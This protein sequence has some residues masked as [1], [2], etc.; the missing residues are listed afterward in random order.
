[1]GDNNL[2]TVGGE[3][4]STKIILKNL[5]NHFEFHVIQPGDTIKPISGINYKY[6]SEQDR[7]KK[8][9]KNPFLFIKYILDT[10]KI[11]NEINPN[12]IHTQ[13]Q[14]SFFIIGM[15]IKFKSLKNNNLVVVHT[16]RGLYRKYNLFFKR[17]FYLFLKNTDLLITTT[18]YNK[19]DWEKALKNRNSF[20]GEIKVIENTAGDL[21]EK[22]DDMKKIKITDEYVI[23]FAGRYCDWKNW[24]LAVEIIEK[25]YRDTKN[26]KVKMAIGCLDK[27]SEKETIEMFKKIE[28][29]TNGNF[30]GY[31]NL[32]LEEM[33]NFYYDLDFFILTSKTN[34]ESFGRTLVEAMSRKTVVFSTD[35]GGTT[36]VI[37]N[38]NNIFEQS[39]DVTKK[40]LFYM[41]N[42]DEMNAEKK[43]N[44]ERVKSVYSLKNN[45]IKHQ[46]LYS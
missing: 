44:L 46:N 33:N 3:Q 2:E 1:M 29:I 9:I 16:E 7:L 8:L 12:I 45:I 19:L 35:A 38:S 20:R 4:E 17:I 26:V 36:E 25:V 31:I 23:G 27:T 34:T 40:I 21:F 5:K 30:D 6:L 10:K 14:V 42:K 37:G 43:Y 41:N 22:F 11:I 24:P 39:E 18:E 32:N 28:K 13:A 15:L